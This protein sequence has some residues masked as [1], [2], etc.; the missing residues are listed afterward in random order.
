[1]LAVVA[2]WLHNQWHSYGSP[3]SGG[4]SIKKPFNPILGEQYFCTW[5]DPT[6]GTTELLAE[7]G[8]PSFLFRSRGVLA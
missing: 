6:H 2:W 5:D 7:Q 8:A 3:F 1:M 4:K